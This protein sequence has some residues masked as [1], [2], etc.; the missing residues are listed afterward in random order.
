MRIGFDAKRIFHN[1]TGL[2]NYGRN[3]VRSLYSQYPD[4][5]YILYNPKYNPNDTYSFPRQIETKYPKRYFCNFF[6]SYWRSKGIVNDLLNDSVE[7]YHGLSAELPYGIKKKGIKSVVTV[8]DLIFLKNKKLYPLI[9]R[10]VYLKKT[11]YATSVADHIIA[12]SNQTKED[13]ISF[14]KIDEGK[15]TVVYQGCDAIYHKTL[16]ESYKEEVK[17]KYNLPNDFILS[18]GTIEPRKNLM[19]IVKA[20]KDINI[21]L[22]AVGKKTDY[23]NTLVKY[24][25]EYNIQDKVIFLQNLEVKELAALYQTSKI[26]CYLSFLE[27]FGIPILESLYSKTPVITTKGGCFLEVGGPNSIYLDP[28]NVKGLEKEISKLINQPN[29][30]EEIGEKGYQHALKFNDNQMA[31]QVHNIYSGLMT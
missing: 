26:S 31:K 23:Y 24:M 2:G 21:K 13:L 10:K 11:K 7:I 14:L 16:S 12:T 8:H 1:S 20:I 19:T 30:R 25:N 6:N 4:H 9:D 17:K 5:K 15:I 22:V 29:T 28:S 3:L 18:V 27:G